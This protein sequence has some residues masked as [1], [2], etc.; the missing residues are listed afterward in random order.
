MMA[1]A[2]R[3]AALSNTHL[4]SP[5]ETM[6]YS[7]GL[8]S[9]P[10]AICRAGSIPVLF[11][12]AAA[13]AASNL[14]GSVDA[15]CHLD[16]TLDTDDSGNAVNYRDALYASIIWSEIDSQPERPLLERS[17]DARQKIR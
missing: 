16:Q 11:G 14:P 9:S 12:I 1:V 8:V 17:K 6:P 7:P 3:V 2:E 13:A 15:A 5:S 10:T 4:M